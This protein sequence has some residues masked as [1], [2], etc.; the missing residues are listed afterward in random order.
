MSIAGGQAVAFPLSFGCVLADEPDCLFHRRAGSENLGDAELVQRLAVLLRVDATDQHE[1]V[2]EGV[3]LRR[4]SMI[5]ETGVPWA[6]D[7]MEM[8]MTSTSSWT[9]ACT[10]SSGAL[11]NPE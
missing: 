4:S 1:G 11:C 6:P 7:R 2:L 5:F 10:T 3:V 8:P 9:A